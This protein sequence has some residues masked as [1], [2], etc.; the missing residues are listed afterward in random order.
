MVLLAVEGDTAKTVQLAFTLCC[1]TPLQLCKAALCAQVCKSIRKHCQS[2]AAKTFATHLASLEK[3]YSKPAASSTPTS[4]TSICTMS[5]FRIDFQGYTY[6]YIS[7]SDLL[8]P[9]AV[10]EDGLMAKNGPSYKALVLFEQQ[11]LTPVESAAF[12]RFSEAGLPILLSLAL[13]LQYP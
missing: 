10:V 7:H 13:F 9:A 11:Y 6:E 1:K 8:S 2:N 12:L 5:G 3:K 4:M